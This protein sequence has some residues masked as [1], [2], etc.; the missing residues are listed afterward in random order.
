MLTIRPP[1]AEDAEALGR[2]CYE[3]FAAIANA[4]N[5]PPDFPNADVWPRRHSESS[6]G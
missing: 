1:R 3:A 6:G 2:I 4:H 5:F